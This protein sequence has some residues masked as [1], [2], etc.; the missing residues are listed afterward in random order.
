[1]LVAPDVIMPDGDA[2]VLFRD[3]QFDALRN[4]LYHTQ[5]RTFFDT[6]NRLINFLVVLVG[7]SV[8]AK[9]A[10]LL[11][12][13]SIW[14]ELG[15]IFLA[16]SQLV[17]DF[18]RRGMEHEFLQRRYYELLSEMDAD[19]EVNSESA[20]RKWSAK[21]VTIAADERL[22]M[23]ALDAA[24]NQALD[25]MHDDPDIQKE[26]RQSVSLWQYSLRHFFSFQRTNFHAVAFGS[27]PQRH[28][29]R[30]TK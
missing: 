5:R 28:S 11:K 10:N 21:L 9:V 26:Y 4:A 13:D 22:T 23:R 7:A 20:K 24:Y 29:P 12:F 2:S 15:I 3:P 17:F 1:V 14:L 18:G 25:A 16:T 27:K 8:A 19:P 6:L 30:P